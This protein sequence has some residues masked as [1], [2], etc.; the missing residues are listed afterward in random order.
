MNCEI[1]CVGTELLLG[2]IVNTNA[3]YLS[4]KLAEMG[5]NVLHQSVVGD[6]PERLASNLREALQKSDMVILT[7]GLGP[8]KDDITKEICCEV[9]ESELVFDEAVMKKIESYF[10]SKGYIMSDSNKKQAFVPSDGTVLNNDNG[11]APGFAIEKKGKCI[12][13]LPGP[14]REMKPMFEKEAVKIL[15]KYSSSCI[16]SHNIRMMGIGESA[17]AEEAGE[18]LDGSNPTVAPYAKD[19]E[20]LLRVTAKAENRETAEKMCKEIIEKINKKFSEYIYGTDIDGIE[21]AVVPLLKKHSLKVAFAESCTGGLTA[22]RITDVPGAS[23]VFECGVVSYSN[24]I[25]NKLLGVNENDLKTFGA[26]SET[27]A[28]QMA[29]GIKNLSGADIGVGITGI[30][31]PDSDGTSKPVGLSYIAVSFK[32]TVICNEIRTSKNDRDY[33]RFVN[34]S[35]A[36]DMVRTVINKHFTAKDGESHE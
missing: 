30:A 25:K 26:V 12:I 21:Y 32:D 11:T 27:V 5:I 1:I 8:T 22:K 2:D 20:C 31:G 7:G 35:R 3:V 13:S 36:L 10:S 16:V 28:K 24:E 17:M 14:P 15:S 18:L 29:V 4:K 9:M 23:S 33:N 6:N 19:G 34:S